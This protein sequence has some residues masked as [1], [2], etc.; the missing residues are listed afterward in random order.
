MAELVEHM[1]DCLISVSFFA[2]VHF[3]PCNQF[4]LDVEFRVFD[5]PWP[6]G[7]KF[8]NADRSVVDLKF[9]NSGR[10]GVYRYQGSN[11][12]G[13]LREEGGPETVDFM[14]SR[15]IVVASAHILPEMRRPCC[16]SSPLVPLRWE[17]SNSRWCRLTIA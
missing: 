9:C 15:L 7:L 10:S 3:L 6:E 14:G 17:V 8:K 16:S 4:G 2:T 1:K 13:F 12:T 11:P 5:I